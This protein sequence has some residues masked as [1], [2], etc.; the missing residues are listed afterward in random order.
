MNS[1]QLPLG[2]GDLRGI[3]TA[4]QLSEAT[5][6]KM[7]QDLAFAFVYNVLGAPDRRRSAVSADKSLRAT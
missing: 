2:R 5:V 1:A 4:R 6:T 7:K 3:A